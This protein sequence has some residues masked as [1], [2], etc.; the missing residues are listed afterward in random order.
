[1]ISTEYVAARE[2]VTK[3]TQCVEV[4]NDINGKKYSCLATDTGGAGVSVLIYSFNHK[5]YEI[6]ITS[7]PDTNEEVFEMNDLPVV[8]YMRDKSFKK[9]ENERSKAYY[10]YVTK[11]EHICAAQ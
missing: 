10:C 1:M 9:T 4:K 2:E 6:V 11:K 5:K 8:G 7:D 3:K